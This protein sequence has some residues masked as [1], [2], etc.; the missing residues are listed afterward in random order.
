MRFLILLTQVEEAWEKAPPGEGDRVY[1]Q[2]LAVERELKEAGAFVDSF[3][4]RPRSEA[5]T[6]RNLPDGE[7]EFI[8]G[9]CFESKEAIGGLYIFEC[10][11]ME[12]AVGWAKRL[13]N[14]GHGA[15][16][17]RPFWE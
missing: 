10:A 7:R 16:E 13:P 9:P 8:D 2:Y 14:Y 4:L 15:I 11:S 12:E 6:L 17:V 5:K 3:R 1:Q